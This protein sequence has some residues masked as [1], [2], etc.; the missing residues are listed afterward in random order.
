MNGLSLACLVLVLASPVI[1]RDRVTGP[2][3]APCATSK[4]IRELEEAMQ[5]LNPDSPQARKSI[6][7]LIAV[8]EDSGCPP[9]LRQRAGMCLGRIGSPAAAAVPILIQ[10]LAAEQRPWA[11]KS[12]GLFGKTASAAVRPLAADLRDSSLSLEDRI[13]VADVL[14]QIGTGQALESLGQELLH[15]TQAHSGFSTGSGSPRR[16][17]HRTMLDAVA[18]AGPEAVGVLPALL[19]SLEHPHSE[20]RRHAC[21]TIGQLGPRAESAV[22]SIFER[23][24]LDDSPEV[25][26]AA[27]VALGRLGPNAIPVLLRVVRD[28]PADLQWRAARTLGSYD[29]R[30]LQIQ[31]RARIVRELAA[32]FG[33]ESGRVRIESLTA[34][35]RLER[36]A[37][38][39]ALPLIRELQAHERQ[40]RMA[41]T[42]VLVELDGLPVEAERILQ[43]LCAEM[44]PAGRSA[45]EILRKRRLRMTE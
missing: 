6:S 34:V 27:A 17:L 16:L 14:G 13:L 30:R 8:V 2:I 31:M 28:A 20:V 36:N 22:D 26:D 33:S 11:L 38:L 29:R 37:Q 1:A 35:W 10:L 15:M 24:A 32:R 19:R 7:L 4:Q 45:R 12:L 9:I 44:N 41:A 39:V 25:R 3:T 43:E 23:L 5:T 18:L 40:F 42:Q 21:Q